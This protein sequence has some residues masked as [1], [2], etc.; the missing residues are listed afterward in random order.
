M[1][2]IGPLANGAGGKLAAKTADELARPVHD[3]MREIFKDDL[4]LLDKFES[5]LPGAKKLTAS[6]QEQ[7]LDAELDAEEVD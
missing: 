5:F 2:S 4:D 1:E 3:K 7:G 6:N